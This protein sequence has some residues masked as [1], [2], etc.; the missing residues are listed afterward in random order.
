MNKH[1][2]KAKFEIGQKFMRVSLFTSMVEIKEIVYTDSNLFYLLD[3]GQYLSEIEIINSG[4]F[5][6]VLGVETKGE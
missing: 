1:N 3:N 4:K 5:Q 2:C 6:L